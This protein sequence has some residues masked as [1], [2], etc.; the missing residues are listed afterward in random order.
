MEH[1]LIYF[2]TVYEKREDRL[3]KLTIYFLCMF[4]SACSNLP[5]QSI[6]AIT[7]LPATS[8]FSTIPS[9][10]TEPGLLIT[11]TPPVE[12]TKIYLPL[13]EITQQGVTTSLTWVYADQTRFA[14][15]YRIKGKLAPDGYQLYCPVNE[16]SLSNDFGKSYYPYRWLS[17]NPTL[18]VNTFYCQTIDNGQTYL[19]TQTYFQDTPQDTK[20]IN[21]T[22]SI[23]LGGFISHNGSGESVQI[24]DYP[25]FILH[26]SI[27]ISSGVLTR[28]IN[29]VKSN[30]GVSVNFQ[31]L[32]L[33]HSI[34]YLYYCINYPNHKQWEMDLALT[35]KNQII[36]NGIVERLGLDPNKVLG[37]DQVL[38]D[39][40]CYRV[41]F[42]F[43]YDG[44]PGFDTSRII[45][46]AFKDLNINYLDPPT[47]EDCAIT[48]KR[49]QLENPS[50]DFECLIQNQSRNGYRFTLQ[51][52]HKPDSMDDAKIQQ[53]IE[54][55]FL[56][57]IH[58]DLSTEVMVP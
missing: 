57:V 50:I 32:E 1:L 33:N 23:H 31:R 30:Q 7:P 21:L 2:C 19:I 27:P 46:I 36:P 18:D 53:L 25:L 45:I 58:L 35:W 54:Q 9:K 10:Q 24:P 16:V 56:A 28:E 38:V 22:A 12:E 55:A 6:S 17:Q 47:Q 43:I 29:L 34:S 39:K 51:I 20:S 4:L 5:K 41:P 26:F 14:F 15:E 48:R 37:Y 11:P 3:W 8:L 44:V 42:K 13:D 49:I 40:R 52:T